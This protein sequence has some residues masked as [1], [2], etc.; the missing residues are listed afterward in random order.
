[1]SLKRL[2]SLV[3]VCVTA[4]TACAVT[5]TG[6]VEYTAGSGSNQ[7]T[8]VIDFDF[9]NSFL[10]TYNWG[11]GESPTGWDAVVA[12]NAA[13]P[14]FTMRY[15]D[16]G[17][18]ILVNDFDYTG[19]TEYDYVGNGDTTGIYYWAYYEGDNEN[20]W[21][22]MTGVSARDLKDGDWDSWVWT[23]SYGQWP[24]NVIRAP[25]EKPVAIPEPVTLALMVLGGL[26]L[27][28]GRKSRTFAN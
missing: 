3:F 25:G 22:N 27:G 17:W 16:Y 1:M 24:D 20:W 18:G 28:N 14:D 2:M 7:A 13:S 23:N 11:H 8:I 6:S 9:K 21:E 15:T 4:A 12:I 10:F 26:R 5:Y 19:A